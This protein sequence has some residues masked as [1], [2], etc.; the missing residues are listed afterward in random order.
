MTEPHTLKILGAI[1]DAL[2]FFI[3]YSMLAQKLLLFKTSAN[4]N[5][6][7]PVVI[8]TFSKP[9][10]RESRKILVGLM[11][12]YTLITIYYNLHRL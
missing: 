10:S 9:T 12:Y 1:K 2:S 11:I 7:S 8:F 3:H 4:V 5:G 6:C